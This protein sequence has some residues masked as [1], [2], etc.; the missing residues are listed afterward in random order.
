MTSATS[1]L[2][3]NFF[4][5][6]ELSNALWQ[7]TVL[8]VSLLLALGISYWLR[9][10]L[11]KTGNIPEIR[12]SAIYRIGF[13]LIALLLVL[14]GRDALK[15]W[16]SINILNIAVPLLFALTLIRL[17]IHVLRKV[18]K[19]SHWLE[20]SEHFI[21]LTVWTGF[22]LHLTGYLP[23]VM[24]TMDSLGFQIGKQRVSLL[25]ILSGIFSFL[26][27][28]L[29]AM[30][31]ANAL[32]HRIMVKEKLDMNLRVVLS[33]LIRA[34]LFVSGILIAL[35][36]AGID[37]TVLSVFSGALGVGIG[38]GLQKIAS[39]YI[40]GFIILLD[41]AIHPGDML[42]V[43]NCYGKVSQLTT[44]YLVLQN[45]DGTES[46]IPNETLISSPVINHTYT[47]RK[48]RLSIPVQISYQSNLHRA[49]EI[50]KQAALKHPRVLTDP[51]AKVF[52]KSFGDFGIN[53][54]MGIWIE[55]PEEGR[56]SLCSDIN[57]EIWNEFQK[58]GIEIPYP[59]QEIRM[60]DKNSTC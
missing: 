39:N 22:A 11:P 33:K 36:L 48:V 5:G 16:H 28:M 21:V 19:S 37:I 60:V 10:R 57:M 17:I 52:L 51:E 59:Q 42:T 13:P 43:D 15:H 1:N 41:R 4:S 53:L 47:N 20:S 12:I 18:F 7:I 54:E 8:I 46:I 14:I 27:T 49:M 45:G 50:M 25:L 40:S 34:C 32:E 23:T 9:T 29:L 24:N 6:L 35:P 3:V 55:D 44:R 31:I 2:F 56:L 26:F 30:W 58:S 38:F